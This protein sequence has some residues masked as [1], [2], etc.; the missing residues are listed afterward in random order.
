M[1]LELVAAKP[2]GPVC[3]LGTVPDLGAVHAELPER[4]ESIILFLMVDARN[5]STDQIV[6]MADSIISRKLD[7]VCVW[8]PDCE[9]V[10]DILDEVIVESDLDDQRLVMTTWHDKETLNEAIWFFLYC[11]RNATERANDSERIAISINRPDWTA[12]AHSIIENSG[13]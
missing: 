13:D 1:T 12:E 2:S 10:H 5:L 6:E 4:A 8:G 11:A 7:Y 9:R 3:R